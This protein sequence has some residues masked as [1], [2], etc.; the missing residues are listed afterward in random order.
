MICFLSASD[1]PFKNKLEIFLKDKGTNSQ[2]RFDLGVSYNQGKCRNMQNILKGDI[3]S[4]EAMVRINQ[5]WDVKCDGIHR[6]RG[7]T[8]GRWLLVHKGEASVL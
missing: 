1:P 7:H 5:K 3:G 4:R 8:F 2:A 6:E